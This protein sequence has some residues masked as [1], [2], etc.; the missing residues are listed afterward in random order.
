[1]IIDR[2]F[3]IE[4]RN[5]IFYLNQKGKLKRFSIEM[6]NQDG[7]FVITGDMATVARKELCISLLK[8]QKKFCL[9]REQIKST[10]ILDDEFLKMLADDSE[11]VFETSIYA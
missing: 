11:F 10:G 8:R 5:N 4:A 9:P 7:T 6:I 3:I 1:M 2:I